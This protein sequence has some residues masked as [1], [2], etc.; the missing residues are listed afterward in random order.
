LGIPRLIISWLLVCLVAVLSIKPVLNLIGEHQIMNTSFDPF[1]LVNTY[2][3]FGSIGREQYVVVFEG[4]DADLPYSDAGWKEY[5]YRGVPVDLK[6]MPP[7][8]APYQLHFD[9]QMWF[10]G[11][12]TPNEYPWTIHLVWKLLHNDPLA[13]RLFAGNPFPDHPPRYVRATWYKY[14]FAPP[15]NPDG[16]W[17]ERE[18][19]GDW[20]PVVSLDDRRLAHWMELEG[21]K[22]E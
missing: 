6:Q 3:A 8:V 5:P 16:H 11:M 13:L 7:I 18:K 17:W 21:W 4:T 15:G 9:W 10:A 20:F 2:G 1:E 19:V 14:K 22:T 12:G